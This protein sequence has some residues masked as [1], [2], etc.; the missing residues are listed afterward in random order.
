MLRQM[1]TNKINLQGFFSLIKRLYHAILYRYLSDLITTEF[2]TNAGVAQIPESV[3]FRI[4]ISYFLP[5]FNTTI[6][7]FT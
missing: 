3:L 2:L 7:P 5:A 1:A 4:I 6:S